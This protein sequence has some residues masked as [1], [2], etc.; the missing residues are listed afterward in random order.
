MISSQEK[1]EVVWLSPITKDLTPTEN[2]KKQ[3]EKPRLQKIDYT[4]I[5]GRL[6]TVSW[7]NDSTQLV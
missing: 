3:R 7:S 4:T 5:V 6:R 2:S 1:K